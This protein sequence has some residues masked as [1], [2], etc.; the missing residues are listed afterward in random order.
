MA[1]I[2][3][4]GFVE[5]RGGC[6]FATSDSVGNDV[7]AVVFLVFSDATG[8]CLLDA[9]LASLLSILTNVATVLSISPSVARSKAVLRCVSWNPISRNEPNCL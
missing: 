5:D 3:S 7:L 4:N 6:D 1:E 9:D 2:W 8:A